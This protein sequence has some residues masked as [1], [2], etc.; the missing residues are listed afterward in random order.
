MRKT[1]VFW[2]AILAITL[3]AA[4]GVFVFA[5]TP[6]QMLNLP[7]GPALVTDEEE[8]APTVTARVA[9]ISFIRGEVRIRRAGNT[10]WEKATLNLP[11]VEGDELS[12]PADGRLEIQFDNYKHVRLNENS[13]LKVIN[14]KD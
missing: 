11:L 10:D 5:G 1:K 4:S 2:T 6:A 14:L 8:E 12:T 7:D 3:F 13:Y 9:R